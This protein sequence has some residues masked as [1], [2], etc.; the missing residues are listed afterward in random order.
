[1]NKITKEILKEFWFQFVI[2]IIWAGYKA[3]WNFTTYESVLNAITYFA[4]SFF[5]LSWFIGQFLR[6]KK[7][8]KIES[9]FESITIDLNK[10]IAEL[11]QSVN[12]VVSSITGSG[13]FAYVKI[14]NINSDNTLGQVVI[15]HYGEFPIYDV[16]M[17]ILNY[18]I[19]SDKDYGRFRIFLGNLKQSRAHTSSEIPLLTLDKSRTEHFNFSFSTRGGSFYTTLKMR[20]YQNKW[21]QVQRTV[22]LTED[23][24]LKID[25]PENYPN[26]STDAEVLGWQKES[27][28]NVK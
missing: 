18:N 4:T 6:I 20:F 8:Q 21:I 12:K 19:S 27:E 5:L 16:T 25:I 7:Q 11:Q 10:L 26:L 28:E 1:M 9:H 14:G 17:E 3:G 13:S 23:K 24:I 15:I 22:S 2:S